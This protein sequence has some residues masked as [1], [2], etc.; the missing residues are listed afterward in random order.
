M[1]DVSQV[2]RPAVVALAV[3]SSL[4]VTAAVAQQL[5][6]QTM[7]SP[8]LVQQ[9]RVAKK[10][11]L[12][13]R[14][15]KKY[16]VTRFIVELNEPAAAVYKGGIAGFE[17]TSALATKSE[18]LQ[19]N[20]PAV[21]TYQQHLLSK[22]TEVLRELKARVGQLEAKY[23]LTLTFNGLVV[24]MPG[25]VAD[26]QA[27]IAQLEQVAG[28]KRVYKDKKYFATTPSSMD[29]I[30]AP[31]VWSQLGGQAE[32]GRD[33]KIAI[34]D[35]GIDQDHP[36]F[37]DNGHPSVSRPTKDD[38]CTTEPTFC[39]DKIIVARWYEPTGDV[40]PDETETPADHNGHGTHVAGTAAG[41][42]GSYTSNG[43]ALNVTGVAPGAHIM[44][45]KA[46]FSDVDGSGSGS[47][48]QLIPALEDAVADG[49]DVINNSWGSGPGG[50]PADSPYRSAFAAAHEA[51]VLTVTA[52]GNDGPG[53]RTVGCPGCIEDGLTVASSQHGREISPRVAA[54]G[55]PEVNAVIGD[56]NFSIT[57]DITGALALASNVGDNLACSAFPAGSF[58]NQI[59]LVQRGNCTFESKAGNVQNA[60]ADAMIVYNNEA[61]L[62]TMSMNA[63]TL[64]SVLITQQAG[65]AIRAEWSSAATATIKAPQLRIIEEQ[66]DSMSSFSSRG[67]NG[68][69]SFLKPDITAPG[70]NILA[71]VPDDTI[72]SLSGT[73]MASPH[74][75]G[76]AAL[77]LDQRGS[78][79]PDQLKSLL[80]TSTDNG[81]RDDDTITPA[82]PFDRGAGRLNVSAAAG[83]FVVVDKPSLAN[84]ACSLSCSFT[85]TFTN[86]GSTAVSF[87]V[88]FNS[89]NP[90][91]TAV[92]DEP[93]FNLA[94]GESKDITFELDS[95]WL[96]DGWVFAEVLA[97]TSASSHPT[98]RLPVA[99][100]AAS[101]DNEAIVTVAHTAG[102]V[103][104]G[105]PFTIN[106][107]GGL[108][109]SS[110]PV[111]IDVQLPDGATVVDGS[112]SFAETR[113]S[114]TNKGLAADERSITWTGSQTDEANIKSFTI[115]SSEFFAGQTIEDVTGSA[116]SNSICADGCD[117][118][119]FT[120]AIGDFGGV[121]L[122]NVLYETVTI[123]TNGII[124]AGEQSAAMSG[125]A[126]NRQVPDS[127]RTAGFWAP[128]WTDLEMGTNVGGGQIN[129]AVVG[130]GT[131]DYLVIEFE[132]VREWDD[133][134][135]DRY[136]FSIWYEL[137]TA[138]V[139]FN[140]I[141]LPTNE[142]QALTIGAQAPADSLGNLGIQRYFDGVG[143]YPSNGTVLQPMLE[144][145]ERAAVEVSFDLMVDTIADA[146]NRVVQTQRDEAVTIDLSTEFAAPGRDLLTLATVS[147]G[148]SSYSAVLPQQINAEGDVTVE[149]VGNAS[150][151]SVEVLTN[152][153]L[154]YL[155]NA[156][157]V[158]TDSFTYRGVDAAGQSTTTGT[159]SVTVV[160]NPPVAVVESISGGQQA[161]TEVELDA[162]GSSDPDGD[163]LSFSWQQLSGTTV[164]IA[165]SNQAVARI[166]V[167]A[168]EESETA[169]FEVTVSDG[170]QATTATVLVIFQGPNVA[171]NASANSALTRV[172]SGQLVT[173]SGETSGDP[174]NDVLSYSWAQTAGTAVELSGANEVTATFTAPTVSSE[175]DLTFRL[176][177]SD[178]QLEDTDDVTI[179]VYPRESGADG[180]ESSGS[181]GVW[182]GLLALPIIWLRRRPQR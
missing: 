132:S 128:F 125:T 88:E 143:S 44:V 35:G 114:A 138:K 75:A 123:S 117:D 100:Y 62:L 174:D 168:V 10:S 135:G 173:L 164:E 96:S 29:L 151:G 71:P 37:A 130:D 98:L 167:P 110:D 33:I 129:Y 31:G 178:G 20:S 24:E 131:T 82:T 70:S 4:T 108:G 65:D 102:T 56:G 152:N 144:R 101:S 112:I 22:Q 148:S 157:F 172:P 86:T 154:R 53:D 60:G 76:A 59:V 149:V 68:D 126:S 18:R 66:E 78:L 93:I 99:I 12:A 7:Q 50:D 146:P 94:A 163:T 28:V 79:T 47:S 14:M 42:P 81:L 27:L 3:L 9:H 11:S 2:I 6:T 54:A 49:A 39:N 162:S 145:G 134:S 95:R 182:L 40:H 170:L 74:V 77:L 161:D 84:N 140:Y 51:G 158:G 141:D 122:D 155:P 69:S 181:F 48:S 104:V 179:S 92:I 111:T 21:K 176:T 119:I 30:S 83:S 153:N 106:A 113:S 133:E 23:H 46:L 177:V 13:Q 15:V 107:R 57:Q 89:E 45:Y 166:V 105:T 147:S 160:N 139:Y 91:L 109:S 43:V 64:P 136:S 103:D 118:S 115:A 127:S 26:Q 32:A 73:S 159:V 165:D 90:E 8:E 137:G 5:R 175:E 67:P 52:A 124:A 120:L 41:N 80:M 61:G 36:L 121:Y 142:P 156:N 72:G 16:D 171:P 97:T 25:K 19:L 87:S 58:D 85:R 1:K 63:A 116:P 17:P 180:E 169:E 34:I 55:L 150:N 38:Y